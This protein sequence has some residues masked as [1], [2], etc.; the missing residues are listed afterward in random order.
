MGARCSAE[1]ADR[2][3]G[4]PRW[5]SFSLW[6]PIILRYLLGGSPKNHTKHKDPSFW[7]RREV[8][9]IPGTMACRMSVWSFVPLV[10][11]DIRYLAESM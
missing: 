9:G 4:L 1:F 10:V 5:V 2:G 8:G 3:V 11:P 6:E 7:F